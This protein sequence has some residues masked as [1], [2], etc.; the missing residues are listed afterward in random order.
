MDETARCQLCGQEAPEAE[1]LACG[2]CCAPHHADCWEYT[3]LCS[4]YGCGGIRAVAFSRGLVPQQ[5][6]IEEGS[7]ALV[8]L[9]TRLHALAQRLGRRHGDLAVTLRAGTLGAMGASVAMVAMLVTLVSPAVLASPSF[10]P[11]V[12]GYVVGLFAVG[13]GY[14]ALAP[15]LAPLQHRAPLRT[16]VGSG[17]ISLAAF[18]AGGVTGGASFMITVLA[19]A[20]SAGSFAEWLVGPHTRFGRQ[21]GATA[22]PLR[23]AATAATFFLCSLAASLTIGL[24]FS[25]GVLGEIGIWTVLVALAASHSMEVGREEYRKHLVALVEGPGRD[26]A[27]EEDPGGVVLEVSG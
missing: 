2:L 6:A 8:P 13:L 26:D 22:T 15:Y 12:L 16:A 14:G 17:L 9:G 25:A 11:V 21:L 10:L 24:P 4:T 5:V 7:Q 19:G 1:A 23:Y 18:F 20:A 27:A 3:G